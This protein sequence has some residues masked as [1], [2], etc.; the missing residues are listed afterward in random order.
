VRRELQLPILT[1]VHARTKSTPRRKA[2]VCRSRLLFATDRAARSRGADRSRGQRE[3]G[4][5]HGARRH[6]AGG[7]EA[8]AAGCEKI[9]L[10]ERGT[11]FGYHDLVVD[12]R[13][14]W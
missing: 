5:V 10:T 7:R 8:I 6:E 1:D 13:G 11:T 9:L 3:E 2:D 4:P 14:W 12:M